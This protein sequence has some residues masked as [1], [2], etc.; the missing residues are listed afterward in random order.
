MY[1]LRCELLPYAE[2]SGE[3]SWA[4]LDLIKKAIERCLV[5]Y[6]LK[7]L[8]DD[9]EDYGGSEQN[10]HWNQLVG[11]LVNP[12]TYVENTTVSP[13]STLCDNPPPPNLHGP[14]ADGPERAM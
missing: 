10:D 4:P 14:S 2:T 8:R 5:L 7:Q 11:V 6:L 1:I 3:H 9:A 12:G 13:P